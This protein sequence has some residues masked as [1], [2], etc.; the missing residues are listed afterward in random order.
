MTLNFTSKVVGLVHVTVK[1]GEKSHK[2]NV[3][4]ING[5]KRPILDFKSMVLLGLINKGR[6]SVCTLSLG[7]ARKE[8][9]TPRAEGNKVREVFQGV[10]GGVP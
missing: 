1:A 2:T 9:V 8:V 4:V 10:P 6:P 7:Q 5:L 3:Y